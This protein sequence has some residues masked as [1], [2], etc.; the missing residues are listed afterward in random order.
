MLG[1]ETG[2]DAQLMRRAIDH[3]TAKTDHTESMRSL[4][5]TTTCGVTGGRIP[6][7]IALDPHGARVDSNWFPP[8]RSQDVG[9][10]VGQV[11]GG[12]TL[13]QSTFGMQ[14]STSTFTTIF[15]LVWESLGLLEARSKGEWN[16][17]EFEKH[18]A[19]YAASCDSKPFR[20]KYL[21][22][23][24]RPSHLATS[25]RGTWGSPLSG[26]LGKLWELPSKRGS[27]HWVVEGNIF[28]A[29]R[30]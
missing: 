4:G 30:S 18:E 10:S 12:A 15:A 22:A 8:S 20:R 9:P 6:V 7:K 17:A 2:T 1:G 25:R 21:E 23:P 3:K 16:L 5:H 11:P 19:S 26:M 24:Y 29:Q 13:G 14:S 28:F 27:I